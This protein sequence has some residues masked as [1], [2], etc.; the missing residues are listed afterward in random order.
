[1]LRSV[2]QQ[3]RGAL[4][5]SRCSPLT[6]AS[7]QK[8]QHVAA[9]NA[10]SAN[11]DYYATTKTTKRFASGNASSS[12]LKLPPNLKFDPRSSLVTSQSQSHFDDEDDDVD[13]TDDTTLNPDGELAT[14]TTKTADDQDYDTDDS[15][16]GTDDDDEDLSPTYLVRPEIAYAIPLPDRL[17]VNVHSLLSPTSSLDSPSLAGTIYLDESVFGRSPVR[18]DLLKR[19]VTYIRNKERGMRK[20]KTKT[21]SEVSGS[22]KKMRKQK[23][24]GVARAGHKRPPHWRGGA[25]AHGPKNTTDYGNTKLNKKV[26]RLAICH[27]FSQKL[28]EGNLIVVDQ[29]YQMPTH[30]TGDFA[31]RLAKYGISGKY[32]TSA[33]ILDHYLGDDEEK[34]AVSYRGVPI[35]LHVASAN[36]PRVKV[37][38]DK[39]TN[40]YE[41]LKHEKLIMS[42]AAIRV[43]EERLRNI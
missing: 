28:L 31:K 4:L 10:T 2:Q 12:M 20:A 14:T 37:G 11:I 1:M 40:V 8:E 15:A 23:G 33:L 9:V 34:E 36:L 24:G 41:I 17:H 35:N 5:R 13:D 18:L 32:G 21:I 3:A 6:L 30:K 22:G 42:L 27:A 39:A 7:W 38:N 26:R 29:F 25:K 19:A 43:I 16:Y